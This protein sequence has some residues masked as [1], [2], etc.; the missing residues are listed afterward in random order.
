MNS[1]VVFGIASPA[2]FAASL[3]VLTVPA[4]WQANDVGA[5]L[6]SGASGTNAGAFTIIGSGAGIGTDNDQFQFVYQP[7]AGDVTI[8]AR[9][10]AS[11]NTGANALAGVM[12]RN[13]L[14]NDV[15]GALMAF[16][17]GTQTSIFEHRADAAGLATYGLKVYG[18]SNEDPAGGGGGGIAAYSAQSA[19]APLWVRLV[20]S[21]NSITGYTSPDGTN[22]T[23]QGTTTVILSPVVEVGLAVSSGTYN[24]L[25]TST[26]DNV[27]VTGNPA[28]VPPP[29]A[30]WKLDET[31]GTTAED[32]I[33]SFDGIYN[34]V[35]LGL[36]GATPDTGYAASFNGTNANLSIPPLNLNSNILTI[37]AWVNR[38][39]N[40]NPSAGIFFNRANSTVSGLTFD[41]STAN[42]L[43]YTW[44]NSSSTYNWHS[45]LIVPNN[46][47]TFVA[48]VIEP[49]R[50]RIFMATN[51]VLVSATNNVAN[52]V[53]AF[54]GT[55]YLGQDTSSSS[56][57][58][59][60]SLDEVQF[61]N[62][63]LTPAQLVQ[64]A[65]PPMINFTAPADGQE[66]LAPA[67]I[68][69]AAA[70]S[71]TNGHTVSLVQYFNNGNWIGQSATPPYTN[72]VTNLAIG[73]YSF[74]ARMY[75]DS[76]AV[77]SSDPA[78]V[79]VET[80]PAV[81][82]N[83]VATAVASNMVY[84]SWLPAAGADG[85]ILSRNGT[86]IGNF[87]GLTYFLDANLASGTS[88]CYT[89]VA[90]N[91]VG[92]SAASAS[93]CATTPGTGMALMWDDG[94]VAG[95]QDGNGYWGSNSVTWWN[96]SANVAWT[97]NNLAVFGAGVTSNCVVTITNDVTPKSIVF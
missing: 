63:A 88:Y 97:N 2:I 85:Y 36:P 40:Q 64:F 34:N 19:T 62:Q 10:A 87:A 70:A 41:N 90:T 50:A 68:S 18:E 1:V 3:P 60:G 6:G 75:Y 24:L 89:V 92:S 9:V 56:R 72:T 73:S 16:D 93:D 4:P 49:A 76:G 13:S 31:S 94:G 23:Q 57:Y 79:L 58:F 69:L 48:L 84:V 43:S 26:F 45:G 27:T 30:E 51:G 65:S 29:V 67:T 53:Q 95:P 66:F 52:A 38:N 78:N 46:L 42:E 17:S 28:L 37:T 5:I 55:S 86:P 35:V 20:R 77:V 74:S 39:G 61:F 44:N 33:D 80:I 21:G 25:N 14:G 32:S 22:W 11:E 47:W 59:D 7:I 91:Q 83:V 71:A 12:I 54:D 15:A 8:T 96:G 82:Q 81:P